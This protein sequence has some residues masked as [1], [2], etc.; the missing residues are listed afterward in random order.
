MLINRPISISSYFGKIC[1]RV[2]DKR[3]RLFL[4]IEGTLDEDQEGFIGGRSTTRYLFRM[5]ANLEEVKRQKLACI[6]LFLDFEKVFDSVHLPSLCVKLSSLG[7]QGNML[8]MLRSFQFNRTICLK[9]NNY[10]GEKRKCTMNEINFRA[11]TE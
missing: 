10:K 1:E 6:V 2:L 8:N 4:D 5:L 9:V 3:L 7:I 11:H